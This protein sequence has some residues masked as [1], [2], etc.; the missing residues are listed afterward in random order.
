MIFKWS[1]WEIQVLNVHLVVVEYSSDI[2]RKS[3]MGFAW[4]I[5]ANQSAD[6]RG[7]RARNDF[8][9]ESC[10]PM[11]ELCHVWPLLTT[12]ACRLHYFLVQNHFP[13]LEIREV[14]MF[15]LLV[16]MVP[17]S[18]CSSKWLLLASKHKVSPMKTQRYT[19]SFF[20]PF[21]WHGFF[22]ARA[23]LS[24]HVESGKNW[25]R[26]QCYSFPYGFVF[27]RDL[28]LQHSFH[29]PKDQSNDGTKAVGHATTFF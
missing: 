12:Q 11:F 14:R 7:C 23:K 16:K 1:T 3:C 28:C 24:A 25:L 17:K 15:W 13:G 4:S 18:S 5:S 20:P 10:V 19:R 8:T 6:C 22:T 29:D 2:V 26:I 21:N 9:S 27:V